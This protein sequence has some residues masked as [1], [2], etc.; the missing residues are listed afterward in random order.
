MGERRGYL[1]PILVFLLFVIALLE[2]VFISLP[3]TL[4][5]VIVLAFYWE[6]KIFPWA[7]WVGVWRDLSS[8]HHL[9]IWSMIF[10]LAAF[11]TVIIKRRGLGLENNKLSL[12]K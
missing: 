10:L 2:A 4:V 6:E 11:L 12:P 8:W 1:W 3:I 7:F 5:L 9:G